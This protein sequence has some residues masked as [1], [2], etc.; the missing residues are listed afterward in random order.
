MYDIIMITIVTHNNIIDSPSPALCGLTLASRHEREVQCHKQVPE[1]SAGRY[2]ATKKCHKKVPVGTVPQ[3]AKPA[4]GDHRR[5]YHTSS[6]SSM[7]IRQE[8]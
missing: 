4:S 3:K 2:S 1:K 7:K 6:I 8:P 5:P